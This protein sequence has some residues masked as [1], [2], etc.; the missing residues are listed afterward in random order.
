MWDRPARD[1]SRNSASTLLNSHSARH[2]NQ[3]AYEHEYGESDLGRSHISSLM[4]FFSAGV[5]TAEEID[6]G[7]RLGANHSIGPLELADLIG[8]AGCGNTG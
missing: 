2:Q 3:A 6:A 5:A 1:Q 7:M 8:L 4:K